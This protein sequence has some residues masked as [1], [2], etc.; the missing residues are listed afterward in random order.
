M[1]EALTAP[2]GLQLSLPPTPTT[3]STEYTSLTSLSQ[4]FS[5]TPPAICSST[6]SP[7]HVSQLRPLPTLLRTK[8]AKRCRACKHILTR[9]ELKPTSTRYRIRLLALNYTPLVSLKPLPA[10]GSSSQ[11]PSP[12]PVD[13]TDVLLAPGRV[14]QWVLNMRNP[15]FE[16]VKVSLGCPAVL[17]GRRGDRVTILCPQFE[18]GANSDVWDDA[19]NTGD[20]KAI[21][22]PG[23]GEQ[24]AGKLYES[25]RN[26][27]GVVLEIVPG[28]LVRMEEE[29]ETGNDEDV[30][31]V[32][33]RVRLEWKVSE[34]DGKE[35][36]G[37]SAR[38]KLVREG[39][40]QDVDVEDEGRSELAYWMVLGVGR[41]GS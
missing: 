21:M 29:K 38:E 35:G 28:N 31:E 13:G 20:S 36:K 15:L 23:G 40:G 1:R 26:W 11:L 30:L 14:S 39:D 34:E 9:P 5:Q 10:P 33:V 19:L 7:N 2:E 32:P 17:P 25:G 41:V 22:S 24:V 27:V 4:R 3:G 12:P 16:P 18:I 8:R 37:K 6:A